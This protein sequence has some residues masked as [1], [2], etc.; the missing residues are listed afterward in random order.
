MTKL[1]DFFEN[2]LAQTIGDDHTIVIS[3][4]EGRTP[5]YWVDRVRELYSPATLERLLASNQPDTRR[6]AAWALRYL[7]TESHYRPLG[8]LLRDDS[9]SVRT[10]ADEA[11]RAICYRTQSPWHRKT[12]YEVEQLLANGSYRQAIDLA[13]HLADETEGRGDVYYLRAWIHFTY[14]NIECAADDCK[15]CLQLDACSYQACVALGQC[16]WH[17]GNDGAAM[18]CYLEAARIYPDWEPART[19]ISVLAG[20]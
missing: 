14:G 2:Y 10:S 11:R 19:A 1:N 17:L 7:G 20:E 15:R 5:L 18:E 6:A 16:Y 13:N 8:A 3:T 4:V 12:A 9:R